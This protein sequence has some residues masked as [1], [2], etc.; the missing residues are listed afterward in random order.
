MG[1]GESGARR[2][3]RSEEETRHTPSPWL[4]GESLVGVICMKVD[5]SIIIWSDLG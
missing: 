5:G 4:P 2:A 1:K 3:E